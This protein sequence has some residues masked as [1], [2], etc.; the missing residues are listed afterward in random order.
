MVYLWSAGVLC[1]ETTPIQLNLIHGKH[2][3]MKCV[4]SNNNK[5]MEKCNVQL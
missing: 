2:H 4:F 5:K 3:V 1:L